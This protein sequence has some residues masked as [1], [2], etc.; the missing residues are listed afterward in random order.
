[1]E[2][3]HTTQCPQ[4]VSPSLRHIRETLA[5]FKE[6]QHANGG[7]ARTTPFPSR[8]SS[9]N[10][11]VKTGLRADMVRRLDVAPHPIDPMG[12]QARRV[13]MDRLAEANGIDVLSSVASRRLRRAS[14][15]SAPPAHQEDEFGGLPSIQDM[16]T[17]LARKI[18]PRLERRLKRTLTVP[19]T[20]TLVPQAAGVVTE[21]ANAPVK[22]VPYLSFSATVKRN[23]SFYDLTT[24]NIEEL[25]GVEY[26]ALC[27]LSWV[28]PAV[29][30]SS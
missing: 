21:D 22:R 7:I 4:D 28:I 30:A 15:L 14:I 27:S 23:S 6:A 13:S 17:S 18:S 25:G 8:R 19:R 3:D 10:R 11:G 26:R 16:L 1:M 24:E 5:R 2:R 12:S 29:N 20:E 9:Q